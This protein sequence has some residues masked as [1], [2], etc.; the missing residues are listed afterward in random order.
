MTTSKDGE[1]RADGIEGEANSGNSSQ[2]GNPQNSN[3]V[4]DTAA[5]LQALQRQVED[6]QRSLQSAKDKGIARTNQRIDGLEKDLK[7]VLQ[8]AAS[9]GQSVQDVLGQIEADEEREAREALIELTRAFRAGQMPTTVS[10]G[11][12]ATGV[13]VTNVLR[14]LELDESDR[15]VQEF[16]SRDFKS[17]A[18]AYREGAKLLK[19]ISTKQPSDADMPSEVSRTRGNP[20]EQQ[21][22]MAEYEQGSKNLRGHALINYK[23]KMRQKGL[24]IS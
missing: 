23:M 17:E 20:D 11:S 16:R 18:E 15:R 4:S 21:R 22:L 10:R 13:N 6:L 2:G 12:D 1:V 24:K 14:E 19:T 8:S 7:S 5:Q 9:K 3:A